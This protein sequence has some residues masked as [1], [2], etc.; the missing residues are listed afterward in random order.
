MYW[1]PQGT[2]LAVQ[3]DRYT[4]SKKTINTSFELF[5]LKAPLPTLLPPLIT[6]SAW[7]RMK[8]WLGPFCSC[9]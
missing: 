5:S 8:D 7:H 1:H 2:Y 3:V 6:F 4:K 9:V